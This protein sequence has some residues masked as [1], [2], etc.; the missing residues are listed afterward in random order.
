MISAKLIKDLERKGFRLDFPSYSSNEERIIAILKEDNER[1]FLAIPLLLM[2][3][4]DYS[5]IIKKISKKLRTEF[6]KIIFISNKIF[7]KE[8]IDQSY[9]SK[10][11]KKN[12]I[13][14]KI[15]DGEFRY[16][17]E[18]FKTFI[19]HKKEEEETIFKDEIKIR[20]ILNTNK[21]LANIFAPGKIRIMNKIFKH[22][23]LTNTELKY[24]YRSIRPL[25]L[26]I[27]N[28]N[29]QKYVRIVESTKKFS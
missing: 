19:S 8:G 20:G 23:L 2:E 24:Y 16:Y 28:E 10:I 5:A 27:L 13:K 15:T 12:E 26:S 7:K 22:E 1:L 14:S 29:L 21:A 3:E 17:Y 18:S 11:I 6:D 9:L 4:F 25:I